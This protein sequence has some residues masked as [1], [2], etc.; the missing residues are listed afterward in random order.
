MVE[1]CGSQTSK[2]VADV[3]REILVWLIASLPREGEGREGEGRGRGGEALHVCNARI[4]EIPKI[5]GHAPLTNHQ[6]FVSSVD[7]DICRLFDIP[8]FHSTL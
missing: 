4:T 8:S 5:L 6:V 1:Q 2:L 3:C 7:I